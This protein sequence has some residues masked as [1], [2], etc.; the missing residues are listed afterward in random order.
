MIGLLQCLQTICLLVALLFLALLFVGLSKK[1]NRKSDWRPRVSVLVS[2]RNEEKYLP[3]LLTDLEAQDYPRDHCEFVLINDA[4]TDGTGALMDQW[5]AQD[6]RFKSVH[7]AETANRTMGPK[8]RALS[9]G[10]QASS[11]EIILT[12]DAD[13]RLQPGWI[14]AMV[15]CFDDET[16]AVCGQVKTEKP[17]GFWARLSAFEGVVNNILN[18]AVIGIG[19]ALSCIGSNFAYRRTAF[20][21]AGG[22]DSGRRSMSGDDDLLLQKIKARGGKIRFCD[23]REA[24][25]TARATSSA[26]AHWLRKR[27]HLSAGKRYAP[28]WIIIAGVV[29]LGCLASVL[30]AVIKLFGAPLDYNFLLKWGIFSLALLLVF[31]RGVRRLNESG[32]LHWAVPA[33]A[34][35]PVIF[36]LIQPLTLLPSPAWKGRNNRP[37]MKS[38]Q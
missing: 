37:I 10:F 4:S 7:L 21:E 32:W 25:V 12:T 36:T 16:S 18:A 31:Y 27:R 5:A 6:Q 26:R 19:G 23:G 1:R 14:T 11:G 2:A 9:A 22:F 20:L 24:S 33:A 30:L 35:F 28:H 8:K 15:A 13:C 34:I 29:Y 38:D 17:P 3:Q